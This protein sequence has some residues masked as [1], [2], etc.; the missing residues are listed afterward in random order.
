MSDR[1]TI[2][3]A[4]YLLRAAHSCSARPKTI[5][6]LSIGILTFFLLF[7]LNS[8]WMCMVG[9]GPNGSGMLI[10]EYAPCLQFRNSSASE[11]LW[12]WLAM[13]GNNERENDRHGGENGWEMHEMVD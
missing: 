4:S 2:L 9:F 12:S 7:T 10:P 5:T 13:G 8:W 3:Q 1:Y 6:T 11:Y